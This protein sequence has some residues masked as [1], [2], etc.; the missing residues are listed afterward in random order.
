M[1]VKC[2]NCRFK[3]EVSLD[4][5]QAGEEVNCTCRRCGRQFPIIVETTPLEEGP[6][7]VDEVVQQPEIEQIASVPT[8]D[9]IEEGLYQ[10]ACEALQRFRIDDARNCIHQLLAIRPN[11]VE[12]LRLQNQLSQ[13]ETEYYKEKAKEQAKRQQAKEPPVQ[14]IVIKEKKKSSSGG[15]CSVIFFVLFILYLCEKCSF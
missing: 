4:N 3:F 12:Y 15:L 10:D 11:S 9:P 8:I 14:Q 2:P 7:E 6:I 13:A 5:S 1:N